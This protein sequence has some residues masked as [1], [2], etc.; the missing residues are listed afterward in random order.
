M[1]GKLLDSIEL[2]KRGRAYIE[3]QFPPRVT[4]AWVAFVS[5]ANVLRGWNFLDDA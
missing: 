4:V 5:Q 2:L 3:Q 1:T